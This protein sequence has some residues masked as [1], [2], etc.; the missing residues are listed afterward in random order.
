M[1]ATVSGQ[2]RAAGCI[3]RGLRLAR[4]A[5]AGDT[6]SD[7][8]DA[9]IE[10]ATADEDAPARA[11]IVPHAG[12][13]Y[14]G[15]TAAFGYKA[16]DP[17]TMCAQR[18]EPRHPAVAEP[19]RA[20]TRQSLAARASSCWAPRTTGSRASARSPPPPCIELCLAM[21]RSMPLCTLSCARA[22]TL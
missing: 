7:Q 22:A 11:L 3:A 6:L 17:S 5:A 13:S 20:L 12:Y 8:L 15:S 1:R 10:A 14:S 19:A 18:N 9:F 16:V 2:R 21:F 4:R